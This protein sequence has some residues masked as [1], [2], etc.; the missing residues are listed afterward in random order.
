VRR[1]VVAAVGAALLVTGVVPASAIS[2]KTGGR[3]APQAI[4]GSGVKP[5]GG[6]IDGDGRS[7]LVV[8]QEDGIR[9][10]YT[11]AAPGGSHVQ[12]IPVPLR[13]STAASTVWL[14]RITPS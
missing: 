12:N 8:G 2:A 14:P 13:C 3:A 7:D 6:D 11:S 10:Y 9:I 5:A 4:S 1:V